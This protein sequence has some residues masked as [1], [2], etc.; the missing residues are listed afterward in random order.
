[1]RNLEGM[2]GRER[3]KT[4]TSKPPLFKFLSLDVTFLYLVL[5]LYPKRIRS[6]IPIET[7]FQEVKKT[8]TNKIGYLQ[9]FFLN[10]MEKL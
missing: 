1:M 8:L 4:L 3:G 6:V 2:L 5:P 7:F 9:T 10:L